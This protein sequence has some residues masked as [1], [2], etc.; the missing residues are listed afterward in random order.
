MGREGAAIRIQ[1]RAVFFIVL[2][3]AGTW[4]A[5]YGLGRPFIF[6]PLYNPN[7]IGSMVGTI[8][9]FS[10]NSIDIYGEYSRRERRFIYLNHFGNFKTGDRVRL[11][12]Y[13]TTGV[14]EDIKRMTP[15]EYRKNGANEGYILKKK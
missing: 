13:V 2:F 12:Y 8:R 4:G 11:Y 6:F 10:R 9:G 1:V 15:V 14:V 3:T 7:G 5:A